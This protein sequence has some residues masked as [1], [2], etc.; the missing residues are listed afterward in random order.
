MA[1]TVPVQAVPNQTLSVQLANQACQLNIYQKTFGLFMDVYVNNVLVLAGAL[2]ENKNKIIRNLYFG[3]VGDFIWVDT[4]GTN[5]PYYTG[6]G[7]RYL[8]VYLETSDLV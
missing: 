2:C 5:D 1:L 4:Q 6:L 8:L 3:F 7:A